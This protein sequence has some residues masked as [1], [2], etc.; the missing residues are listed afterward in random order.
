M[1]D[2]PANRSKHIQILFLALILTGLFLRIDKYALNRSF[3]GDEATL[4]ANIIDR[5]LVEL[6]TEPLVPFQVAPVGFLILEKFVF[7]ILGGR[8]YILRL[9]P[10]IAGC[11]AVVLMY[12]LAGS[13]LGNYGAL[14]TLGAFS[15]NWY[16]VIYSSDLKQYSGDAMIATALYV[17][18]DQYLKAGT[19]K[20]YFALG[21]AGL[22]AII[23]SQPAV[24]VIGGIGIALLFHYRNERQKLIQILVLSGLWAAGF[25]L[26]YF[27]SLKDVG[28]NPALIKYWEDLNALMPI[29]PWQDPGW[30]VIRANGLFTDLLG[31]PAVPLLGLGLYLAGLISLGMGAKWDWALALAAPIFLTVLASGAVNYPFKGRVIMFLIPGL[32]LVLGEAIEVLLRLAPGF[33]HFSFAAGILL[34]LFLLSGPARSA[35]TILTSPAYYPFDEDIRPVVAHIRANAQAGDV[36][37]LSY[38]AVGPFEYYAPFYG[39]RGENLVHGPD[40]RSDPEKYVREVDQLPGDHRVWFVFSNVLSAKKL[41]DE[42]SYI[43]DHLEQAGAILLDQYSAADSVSSAYLYMLK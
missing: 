33:R 12:F 23:T 35:L 42:R 4:A 30:F 3:R 18:F 14:F 36:I 20:D 19:R 31:L 6:A 32:L 29:P 7:E 28:R 1:L 13:R 21:I 24:F 11:I 22:L 2:L 38:L 34:S 41:G 26:L 39:I 27:I 5:S 40:F 37:F 43:T 17:A 16:L 15:L 10:L 8:D 25:M 9:L